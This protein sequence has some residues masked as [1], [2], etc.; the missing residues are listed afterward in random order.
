LIR[1]A[2]YGPEALKVIGQAF[3][4]AWAEIAPHFEGHSLQTEAAR[5]R[6]AH[7]VLAVATEDERDAAALRKTALQ[8]FALTYRTP[9]RSSKS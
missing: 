3:D 5:L 8:V 1:G 7:A 6:L 9:K 4:E 2:T